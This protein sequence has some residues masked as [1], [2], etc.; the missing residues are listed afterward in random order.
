MGKME[1][2]LS[3]IQSVTS[4]IDEAELT[5]IAADLQ[6]TGRIFVIG[7]GRSG[8]MAKSFAMR[9]M[10][11]GAEV[12]VIGETITPSIKEDDML[13]AISG[14]GSTKSV[15]WTAEKAK[16]LGCQ[17]IAVTTNPDS[18][19]A[20]HASK[21]LRVPAA[22]KYRREDERQ[23]IQPLGSLFDQ[24][25]HIVFDTICLSYAELKDIGHDQAFKQHSNV[26]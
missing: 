11:L 22:T 19:L 1:T 3:E 9:L 16:K 23:T 5:E 17:V 8:L 7:E 18:D 2:I 4:L 25:A 6:R 10:H 13:V 14:S 26:E 20:S 15:V 21:V 24:C 12:Y